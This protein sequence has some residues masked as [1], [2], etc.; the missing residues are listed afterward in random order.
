MTLL[1]KKLYRT[2]RI[3][4]QE[5]EKRS[6]ELVPVQMKIMPWV[7]CVI[8]INLN[9]TRACFKEARWKNYKLFRLGPIM[10]N[11]KQMTM[12]PLMNLI[13]IFR[14]GLH[15]I[16]GPLRKKLN[17]IILFRAMDY[18]VLI[19]FPVA[20]VSLLAKVRIQ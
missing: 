8:T 16:E 2:N 13:S 19:V 12:S 1:T 9:S 5:Y 6:K 3:G 18:L 15:D 17:S 11:R 14:A 20:T 10:L 4:R 7:L